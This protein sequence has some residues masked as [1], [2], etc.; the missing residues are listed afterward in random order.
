VTHL[1]RLVRSAKAFSHA[2]TRVSSLGSTP[3]PKPKLAPKP[4]LGLALGGGFARGLSHVGVLKV[5]E[6][7]KI[8]IDYM[9]GTSVGS[10]IAAAFCSGVSAKELEEIAK[11]V[12]FRDFARWTVSRYGICNNDRM[13]E[14]LPRVVKVKTFEELKI[15][16]AV[17]ATDFV[18][19]EPVV[20][21][22]G[23]ICDPVRASC[24]YPGMFAPVQVAGQWLVDGML[25][26]A[27]PSTP[28]RE[29]G[30]DY[31][32]GVYLN[33]HWVQL[34]GPR[35][36]FD[37]IGQCFSIAQARMSAQWRKD[38]DLVLEP[39]VDG[40]S[41]DGFDRSAEL[42]AS[43]ERAMR[44]ALPALRKFLEGN[45]AVEDELLA[46]ADAKP[47]LTAA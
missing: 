31:V 1:Q 23:P 34:R 11:M 30:A 43:G 37:V 42:I 29:M 39:N 47:H 14:F 20:F 38:A 33:A 36:L 8:A 9:A 22:S 10:V 3:P 41:Y 19:G 32:I 2:L 5:L 15:P 4:K 17:A 28:L 45:S 27:V 16:L 18:T 26:H 13:Q 6:E 35:H 12:R 44:A 7:E 46:K 24:A 40:F 25:G 21:Q